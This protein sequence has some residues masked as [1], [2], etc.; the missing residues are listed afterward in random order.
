MTKYSNNKNY[1]QEVWGNKGKVEVY[2]PR[3]INDYNRW[4][5]GVD[6]A[7]QRILYYNCLPKLILKNLKI[8][9]DIFHA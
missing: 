7:D 4:I 3:L 9:Y 2:I 8:K 6:V 1:V 5:G